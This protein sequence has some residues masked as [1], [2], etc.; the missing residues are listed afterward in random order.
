MAK[1][2]RKKAK[3]RIRELGRAVNLTIRQL[4]GNDPVTEEVNKLLSQAYKPLCTA[5]N[6]AHGYLVK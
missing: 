6:V 4:D 5:F 3:K 2:T 1:L